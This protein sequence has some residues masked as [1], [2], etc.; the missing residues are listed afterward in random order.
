MYSVA[1]PACM[2]NPLAT[3]TRAGALRRRH[4]SRLRVLLR[5]C[6]VGCHESVPWLKAAHVS[7]QKRPR[8]LLRQRKLLLWLETSPWR[9]LRAATAMRTVSGSARPIRAPKTAYLTNPLTTRLLLFDYIVYAAMTGLRPL[10]AS[11][12]P[13]NAPVVAPVSALE[14][15]A[16]RLQAAREAN[17][18]RAE[19]FGTEY[20][21][22][23]A[24][25]RQAQWQGSRRHGITHGSPRPRVAA[26]W[27]TRRAR[28]MRRSTRSCLARRCGG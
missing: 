2:P 20:Q 10:F 25:S 9:A 12:T 15:A 28:C 26:H 18:K 24:V 16:A 23:N 4:G 11:A 19:R 3:A 13:A 1:T 6:A 5:R 7:R 8:R 27:L 17:R 22:P 21:E 14:D